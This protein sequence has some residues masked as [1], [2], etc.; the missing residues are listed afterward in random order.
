MGGFN[1]FPEKFGA[2]EG[3]ILDVILQSLLETD[4]TAFSK[5]VDSY[6]WAERNAEAR[7]LAYLW[8]LNRRMANQWDPLRMTDFLPRWEKILGIR[9]LPIET[10]VER[11]AKVRAKMEAYGAPPTMQVVHDLLTVVLGSIYAGLVHTPSSQAVGRVPGGA[12]VPGGVT[13]ADGGWYSTIAHVAIKTVQPAGVDDATFYD[14][15]A[16]IVPFLSDL[17][18]AWVTFDWFLDGAHGEGFYLDEER[19]LDNQRF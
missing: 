15:V 12:T 16:Q 1:P 3:H 10:E 19:N 5:E 17:L 6:V 9:P 4:G 14:V 11:R 13:L 7:A 18:P 8:H 2:E